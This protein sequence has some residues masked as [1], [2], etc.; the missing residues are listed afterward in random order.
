MNH[1]T[2]LSMRPAWAMLAWVTAAIFTPALGAQKSA[3]DEARARYEAE[4]A[5]CTSGR[6]NQDRATCLREAGAA[7]AEARRGLLNNETPEATMTNRLKRCEALPEADRQDC[8]ARMQGQ[9]TT[10]GSPATGGV[11]R[12]LVTR[13]V[14]PSASAP[15]SK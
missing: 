8:M 4:R 9:G 12:E 1:R 6:S 5:A 14:G 2:R 7:Y 15:T 11:Y 13:D 3:A 10:T